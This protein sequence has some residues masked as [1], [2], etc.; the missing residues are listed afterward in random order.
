M[1]HST[2]KV[3]LVTLKLMKMIL[4]LS[5]MT[6]NNYCVSNFLFRTSAE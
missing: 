2:M 4:I 3:K 5:Q 1:P 6:N